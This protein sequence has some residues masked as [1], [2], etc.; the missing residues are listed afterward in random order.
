[1]PLEIRQPLRGI[2]RR[3]AQELRNLL[4]LPHQRRLVVPLIPGV[5]LVR[6]LTRQN[7]GHVLAR[8]L[9]E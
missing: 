4:V 6:A 7:D 1:M 2:R 5:N 9:R 3:D 8:E